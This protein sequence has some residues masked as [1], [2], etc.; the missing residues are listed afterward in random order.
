MK[1]L[2]TSI[3]IVFIVAGLLYAGLAYYYSASS[4]KGNSGSSERCY[5]C[6]TVI[7]GIYSTGMTPTEL[8]KV[9]SDSYNVEPINLTTRDNTYE[10]KPED[11]DYEID[12]KE[13]LDEIAG[14][15]SPLLWFKYA[16][17]DNVYEINPIVSFD[18]NKFNSL[19]DG[20]GINKEYS[21]K[22]R[23]Y[24]TLTKDGYVL[25]DK[26]EP[27]ID[28]TRLK[29]ACKASV[30]SGNNEITIDDSYY[31]EYIYSV[32]ELALMKYYEKLNSYQSRKVKYYFGSESKSVTPYEWDVLLN[33]EEKLL[34]EFSSVNEA[35]TSLDYNV[36]EDKAILFIDDFLNEYNTYNNR[37][38]VTHSKQIVHVT[39]GNYGN[40]LN[41]KKEE[42]WFKDFVNSGNQNANRVPEYLIEAKY[43]EKN[44]FGDTFIEVSLDEQHLWYYVDGEVYVDTPITSGSMAHGGTDPRV[45]Y[46]YTKIPNKWLNGPTWHNFVKY[47]VA[48]QGSIGIHDASWRKEYGGQNYIYNGSHGCINTPLDAMEKIFDRVE[49]GTPVI[50][51]SL[52]KNQ[53]KN[54]E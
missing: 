47:W 36:P 26:S 54:E 21:G 7:N 10:I 13:P 38:F 6:G 4:R 41:I 50:V 25:N 11:I 23:V 44:D 15:Q 5:I 51:Y 19:L 2:R 17:K 53:V 43:R 39:K 32:E 3:I 42:D 8:S 29:E 1:P 24:V 46:V 27:A 34:E 20:F 9:L 49:I 30:K 18:E 45:V 35:Q 12:F 31:S 14:K 16:F 52:D 33:K 22:S 28:Y 40:K 37:Y 48:I